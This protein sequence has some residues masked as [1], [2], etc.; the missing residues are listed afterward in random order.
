MSG[1]DMKKTGQRIRKL[2]CQKGITV[3]DIQKHLFIGSHQAIYAWFAGKSLPNVDN[4]YR[5]SRLLGV[6]MDDLVVGEEETESVQT[7][8]AAHCRK[9]WKR[10]TAYWRKLAGK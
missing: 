10:M 2:C 5:L 1:I 7:V 4:L 3:Q 8:L 6:S 9:F